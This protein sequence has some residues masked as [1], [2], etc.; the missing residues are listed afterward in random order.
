MKSLDLSKFSA[1]ELPRFVRIKQHFDRQ[2]VKDIPGEVR[3][4]MEPYLTNLSGKRI[5]VGVGSRGVANIALIAKTVVDTLK[6]AGAK[7]F[8]IP[9]MGSHGGAA[10][11]GQVELLASYGITEA[12][13]GVS[14]DASMD[15]ECIGELEPG[16]PIYVAKS[17]LEADGIVIIP[18]VKPH[19]CFRGP[20]ESGICKMLVIGLGKQIGAD[21]VHS[22]GF[23]SFTELIPKVGCMIASRTNVLFAVA[24]VENAFEDTYKIEVVPKVDILS[25]EREKVLLEEARSL[26]GCIMFDK[27]DVLVIDEIGKN[28]SG[29][30]QDP[31][32][33]GLYITNCV[34]G[35]P[36]F[37]K[38][39]IFDVTEESHGNANGVGMVD[40]TTRKLF[41]KI[42]YISM[43]TN[44]Y[45]STEVEAAK[46]PMVAS[47]SEDAL[48]L[49]VKM[50]T[51]VTSRQHKIVWIKNT[52]ELTDVL[53]SEP[54]LTE[55]Q[56]N[57]DIEVISDPRTMTFMDGEPQKNLI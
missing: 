39:V 45:T 55:A 41:D 2:K 53:I 21:S 49:A 31:N 33:T 56:E 20:I 23:A 42:D 3:T 17:A 1:I 26:M 10:A 16:F 34:S 40:V 11:E 8:I 4:K 54:L 15:V 51:G 35:G 25:L 12:A 14:V 5:A 48:R 18:R 9:A 13:M 50:C 32:V 28:I 38:S 52:L 36:E 27:F 57:P 19:T 22:H 24:L 44:I 37:K 29:D 46:I 7:P 47:T 6:E 30:G 43:Y